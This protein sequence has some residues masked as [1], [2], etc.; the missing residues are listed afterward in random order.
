MLLGHHGVYLSGSVFAKKMKGIKYC[1][2]I[3][4]T[5]DEH[6]YKAA[7]LHYVAQVLDAKTSDYDVVEIIRR[8]MFCILDGSSTMYM[9]DKSLIYYSWRDALVCSGLL[10]CLGMPPIFPMT[11]RNSAS[12][13]CRV[14]G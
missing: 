13:D 10:Y 4:V 12:V 11:T 6:K 14:R 8:V 9:K 1:A 7:I 2:Y 5:Y 3:L